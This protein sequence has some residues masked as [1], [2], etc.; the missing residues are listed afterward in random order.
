MTAPLQARRRTGRNVLRWVTLTVAVALLAAGCGPAGMGSSSGRPTATPETVGFVPQMIS[1]AGSD[2]LAAGLSNGSKRFG[3]SVLYEGPG[4]PVPYDQGQYAQELVRRHPSAVGVVATDPTVM[5]PTAEIAQRIGVLFFA[6]ESNVDCPGAGLF[7]EPASPQAIGF[8]TVD[9]LAGAI[10]GSGDVAIVSADPTQPNLESWIHYMQ[11]RL[12]AYPRLH[13][14][15][16]QTGATGSTETVVV[17]DRLLA[18]YPDLKGIIGA[19]S[20]NVVGLARAVDQAGRKGAVAL[21]GVGD[22][23][24][25][26]SDIEDGTVAGVMSYNAEHLGYLTYWAVTQMLRHRT[27][28]PMLTVPGLPGPMTWKAADRPIG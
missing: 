9:L 20:A 25:V 5:C 7:V 3:G 4:L 28:A 18:A 27:F 24:A 2:A 1:T 11:V 6:T 19:S 8:G 16:V 22:L 21:S 13:L 12:A 17:A 15:P 10:K 26:R 14:V 23:T